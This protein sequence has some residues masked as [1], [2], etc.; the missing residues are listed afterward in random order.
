M[1]RQLEEA[2]N[3]LENSREASK[4]ASVLILKVHIRVC[5]HD[6]CGC[7]FHAIPTLGATDAFAQE[8]SEI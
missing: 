8:A 4:L 7:L 6:C 3:M 5:V 2:L 1:W